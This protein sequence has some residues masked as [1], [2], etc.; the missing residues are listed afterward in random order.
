[1]FCFSCKV[2]VL[3]FLCKKNI[4]NPKENTI[5]NQKGFTMK[6]EIL[7]NVLKSLFS[8]LI[9]SCLVKTRKKKKQKT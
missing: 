5:G 3:K 8:R 6:N 4:S 1:M 9:Y 2:E 7:A